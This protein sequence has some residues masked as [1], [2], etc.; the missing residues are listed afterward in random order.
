MP[1]GVERFSGVPHLERNE[2]GSECLLAQL[3]IAIRTVPTIAKEQAELIFSVVTARD[4]SPKPLFEFGR[5]VKVSNAR[6]AFGRA[7][8]AVIDGVTDVNQFP[9]EVQILKPE[10]KSL[11]YSHPR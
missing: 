4:E 2:Q 8:R 3:I 10:R 6:R 1:D 9:S 11:V 5:H 7:E